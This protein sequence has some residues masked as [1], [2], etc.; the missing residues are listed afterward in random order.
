M[1]DQCGHTVGDELLRQVANLLRQL[2]RESDIVC[3]WGGEEFAVLTPETALGEAQELAERLRVAIASDVASPL[4]PITVSIGVAELK[5]QEPE[6]SLIQRADQ[7][8]YWAKEKGR[9]RVETVD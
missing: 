8:L 3:R 7:A 5:L 4:G 9:N 6:N 1:N 2:A